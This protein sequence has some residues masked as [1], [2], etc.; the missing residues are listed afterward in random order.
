MIPREY[1]PL[2]PPGPGGAA[3][4]A[5]DDQY[6]CI[7]SEK[8]IRIPIYDDGAFNHRD[9]DFLK[10]P[11]NYP[12]QKF[13]LHLTL[14]PEYTVGHAGPLHPIHVA[15]RMDPIRNPMLHREGYNLDKT[16]V[17]LWDRVTASAPESY[18]K[19]GPCQ[20]LPG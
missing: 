2:G 16:E 10:E 7:E 4:P 11:W 1:L 6:W 14:Q 13:R 5:P 19:L 18:C 15:G 20:Q 17:F 3:P 9:R 12:T 8:H